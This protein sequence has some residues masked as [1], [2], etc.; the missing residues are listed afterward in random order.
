[1]NLA[2]ASPAEARSSIPRIL[3]TV[4]IIIR[5][6]KQQIQ[7]SRLIRFSGYSLQ[8]QIYKINSGF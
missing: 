6:R 8:Q 3:F 1:M 4:R 2:A 7:L 5:V